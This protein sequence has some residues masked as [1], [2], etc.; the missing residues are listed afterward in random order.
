MTSPHPIDIEKLLADQLATAS[1]DLL[2]GLLSTFIQSVDERR[3]R[4]AVQRRL[5]RAQR[6]A[7]RAPQT[8]RRK[9]LCRRRRLVG[10]WRWLGRAN[11][12]QA[13]RCQD[14]GDGANEDP[15][16]LGDVGGQVLERHQ[17][18]RLI[19]VDILFA[20]RPASPRA[21]AYPAVMLGDCERFDFLVGEREVLRVPVLRRRAGTADHVQLDRDVTSVFAAGFFAGLVQFVPRRRQLAGVDLLVAPALVNGLRNELDR[22]I[23]HRF[24]ATSV[25]GSG[26]EDGIWTSPRRGEA[27]HRPL[28]ACCGAAYRLCTALI[29]LL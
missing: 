18:G 8:D 25:P 14:G 26:G 10:F 29:R 21:F 9:V 2:R 17:I 19:P 12:L 16:V 28:P 24:N 13:R 27:R 4:R 6:R 1:P 7:G 22:A 11:D 20:Q 23:L 3:G 15:I 5:R